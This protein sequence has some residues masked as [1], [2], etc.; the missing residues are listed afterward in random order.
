MRRLSILT[1]LLGLLIL[2]TP[3]MAGDVEVFVINETE[4]AIAVELVAGNDTTGGGAADL[5]AGGST[6]FELSTPTEGTYTS[7]LRF[8]SGDSEETTV[9]IQSTST[10]GIGL[11]GVDDMSY[12]VSMNGPSS[13]TPDVSTEVKNLTSPGLMNQTAATYGLATVRITKCGSISQD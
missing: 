13:C 7:I 9:S 8:A 10:V 6:K 5:D 12:T 11:I 1:A 2:T 3:A 4:V